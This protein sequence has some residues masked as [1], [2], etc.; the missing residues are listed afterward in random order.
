MKWIFFLFVPLF[1]IAQNTDSMHKTYTYLALG[2]SYTI[3]ESLPLQKSFPY[4]T[5]QLLRK[6]GFDFS[7]PEVIAKTGWTTDELEAAMNGYHFKSR[8]DFVS[9]LI[10]VNNQYRNGSIIEFKA[11]FEALLKKAIALAHNNPEHVMVISIP[12]YSCTPYAK[13]LDTE[14]ISKELDEYNSLSKAISIQYKVAYV[15]ITESSRK[16]KNDA[17]LTARDGLHP[18]EKEYSKW[19]KKISDVIC[20]Y[21]K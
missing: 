20:R 8:Y 10:G 13:G 4:Q 18:S 2:D 9:L 11:G 1:S 16:E 7:A 5:V 21:L 15:E 12:D 17:S 19:A 3:G 14:K 6:E